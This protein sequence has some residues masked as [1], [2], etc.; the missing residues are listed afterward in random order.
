MAKIFVTA[1]IDADSLYMENDD[2]AF[3][4]I[5]A[6]DDKVATVEFTRKIYE[7]ARDLLIAEGE[8]L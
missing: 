5:K 3:E 8:T 1:E 7:Y 6:M 2:D 4:L